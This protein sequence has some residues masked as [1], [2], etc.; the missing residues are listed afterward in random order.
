M[1]EE[2]ATIRGALATLETMEDHLIVI[3]AAIMNEDSGGSK[4]GP[5]VWETAFLDL[6]ENLHEA[7]DE[8]ERV[9]KGEEV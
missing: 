5:T 4:I 7:M 8:L 2:R 6:F 3:R 1:A 9:E